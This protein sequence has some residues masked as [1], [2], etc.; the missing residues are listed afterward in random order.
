MS[1]T[2]SLA[3]LTSNRRTPPE[4]ILIAAAQGYASVGLRLW[5]N[6]PG[7]P[8]QHLLGRP[9]VL[10]ET[11][12]AQRD[13]GVAVFDLEI[14]RIG[15]SFDPHIWGALYDAGAALGARAMLVAGDD[16]DEAR[17]S[18]SY[19]R[20]C[21]VMTTYRCVPNPDCGRLCLDRPQCSVSGQSDR[22]HLTD[23]YKI[24]ADLIV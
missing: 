23:A 3:Y 20:M 5:P 15:E 14:I 11:Q 16:R 17:P 19:A 12:A 2:Y 1:R 22:A 24:S 4:A 7:A 10:R 21:E 8:Q 18:E 9:D 13:T 6:A